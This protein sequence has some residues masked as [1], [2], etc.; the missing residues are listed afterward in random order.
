MKHAFLIY[1]NSITAMKAEGTS[2]DQQVSIMVQHF[3][4]E[5]DLVLEEMVASISTIEHQR[6]VLEA[7]YT[8]A[9][10]ALGKL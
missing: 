1:S 7:I 6:N 3:S 2:F 10:K 5:S 4:E 9:G 8:M